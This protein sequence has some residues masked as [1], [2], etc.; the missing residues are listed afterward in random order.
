MLEWIG[1][2]M[3]MYLWI[4]ERGREL[5][6]DVDNWV[7]VVDAP[8]FQE[9]DID[10][11][12]LCQPGCERCAR[13]LRECQSKILDLRYQGFQPICLASGMGVCVQPQGFG[14]CPGVDQVADHPSHHYQIEDPS[15][16]RELRIN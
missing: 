2:E 1:D 16:A 9:E 5:G 7:I 13:A 4:Q 8:S 15:I 11:C 14:S 10:I 6:W 3:Y 12:I